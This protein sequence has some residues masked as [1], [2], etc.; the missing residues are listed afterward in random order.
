MATTTRSRK[1]VSHFEDFLGG[2]TISTTVGEGDWKITD[3]STTG[4]PTY[5]RTNEHGG[6]FV[7]TFSNNAE[8]QN[9]CLDYGN[10]LPYDI[11]QL[12]DVDFRIK[13]V[14]S[15]S[16]T[17]TLTFGL[18]TNRDD[19]PDNTTAH[20]QFQL[21]GSNA[22]LCETD[23]NVN[24]INNIA[25]GATLGTTYRNFRISFQKGKT[26][27][28]FFIDDVRVAESQVFSM[29]NFSTLLQP[30]VQIQ[31]TANN[32]TDSVSIDLISV[33]ARRV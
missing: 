6:V 11:D 32:N 26:D 20:A 24:D 33:R 9:L 18:Q 29:S 5:V 2:S 10:V 15:L 21:S 19:N 30:F 13:T 27:I 17:T 1:F 4:T 12:L 16:A 23:D 22:V 28:R 8:I 25:T 14:A 7:M 31:K 3:T